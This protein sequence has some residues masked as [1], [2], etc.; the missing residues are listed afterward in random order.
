[1]DK[2]HEVDEFLRS[3]IKD[4]KHEK[5]VHEL[6]QKALGLDHVKPKYEQASQQLQMTRQGFAALQKAATEGNLDELLGFFKV[7]EEKLFQHV[8]KRLQYLEMPPEQ[9]AELDRQRQ[10]ETRA[11]QAELQLQ[12]YQE[13]F[14][15]QVGQMRLSQLD[16]EISR[17]DIAEAAQ[18]FD[19]RV[20][21]PGAFRD[22]VIRR[23]KI[24]WDE[25]RKDLPV[26]HAVKEVMQFLGYEESD[27]HPQGEPAAKI[28][29]RAL[30][31]KLPTIPNLGTGGSSPVK[32]VMTSLA[33]L[34]ERAKQAANE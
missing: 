33:D 23:G 18:E 20:G 1:M 24:A 14:Q 13:S 29:N 3:A 27:S 22:E 9:R 21:R 6:Y 8:T 11:T 30:Q 10:Q 12:Q 25:T 5:R 4:Q 34:R 26:S 7:P 28:V 32:K 2:E 31:K 19:S 15:Q 16:T 17:P